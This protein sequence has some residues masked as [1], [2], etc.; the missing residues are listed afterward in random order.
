MNSGTDGDMDSDT[1][2]SEMSEYWNDRAGP[3]WVNFQQQLD[4]QIR[5]LGEKAMD[6]AAINAGQQVLDIGCGCGDSA[7]ELARRVDLSAPMLD[8]A[9]QRAGLEP[10]LNLD[11]EQVDAQTSEFPPAAYDHIFSRL[12]SCFSINRSRRSATCGAP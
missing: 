3:N 5:I 9:R 10:A 11:F 4:G 12:A 2:N 1:A 6:Q 7:L 8:H